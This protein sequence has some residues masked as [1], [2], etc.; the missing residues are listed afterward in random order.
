MKTRRR[1][2]IARVVLLVL[3]AFGA[4]LAGSFVHTDDGCA[5]E[6][7]CRTCRVAVA[8]T[9]TLPTA[10]SPLPT[11]EPTAALTASATSTPTADPLASDSNRGPPAAL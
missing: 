2:S 5:V 10:A 7:H 1:G 3:L 6:Q 8:S 9:G 11:L 4:G